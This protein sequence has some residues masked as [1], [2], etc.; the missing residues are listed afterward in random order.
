[1]FEAVTTFLDWLESLILALAT[2]PGVYPA[3]FGFAAVDGFFPPLPSESVV[4]TLAVAAQHT[5]SPVLWLVLLM[6]ALGAWVGDQIA[7]QIGKVVGT[8]RVP[9]LRGPRGRRAVAWA[10]GAL[11]N[12]AASF[13]LAA[14]YVPIGRVAVNMT[15]GAL[16]YPRKR[17]MV[18]AAVAAVMWAIYS[19]LIG[20]VAGKWIGHQPLLAIAIGVIMGVTLG[21][22]I[23][24]IVM[25]VTGHR[26]DDVVVEEP[27]RVT[28]PP[29]PDEPPSGSEDE[30]A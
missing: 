22:V 7:Y 5:G 10:E 30:A 21:F 4:I 6:A 18:V 15:A 9:F 13:I 8:E 27:A 14:R 3:M 2:S 17:F 24:K 26:R 1:M 11:Q 29:Q 28:V 23:D 16:G 12:R 19:V 20:L 25:W